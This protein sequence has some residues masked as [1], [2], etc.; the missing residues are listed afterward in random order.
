[1]KRQQGGAVSDSPSGTVVFLFLCRVC[2]NFFFVLFFFCT[3]LFTDMNI[4]ASSDVTLFF[5]STGHPHF[6]NLQAEVSREASVVPVSSI[7]ALDIFFFFHFCP[8]FFGLCSHCHQVS[9]WAGF[10]E[11]TVLTAR[12]PVC[13]TAAHLTPTNVISSSSS[14]PFFFIFLGELALSETAEKLYAVLS[15]LYL[16]CVPFVHKNFYLC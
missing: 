13:V 11:C 12:S 15:C 14:P 9:W 1:M 10:K 2:E 16:K 4:V 5:F 8:F 3:F 6:A 7:F